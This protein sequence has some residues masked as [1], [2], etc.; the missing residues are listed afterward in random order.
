MVLRGIYNLVVACARDKCSY[1]D[2]ILP[3]QGV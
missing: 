3:V 1:S 2:F